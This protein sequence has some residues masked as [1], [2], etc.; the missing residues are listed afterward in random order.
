VAL[1]NSIKVLDLQFLEVFV[2]MLLVYP[3]TKT[4]IKRVTTISKIE[5]RLIDDDDKMY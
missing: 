5:T 1:Q 3:F 2:Q 4:Y